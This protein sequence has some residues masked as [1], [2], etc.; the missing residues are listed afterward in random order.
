MGILQSARAVS[1]SA[2]WR[3]HQ[4][5]FVPTMTTKAQSLLGLSPANEPELL[6]LRQH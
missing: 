5:P 6:W 4:L 2:H 3:T 1:G